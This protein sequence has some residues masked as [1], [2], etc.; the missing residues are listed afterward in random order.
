MQLLPLPELSKNS[1][2][3]ETGNPRKDSS[4]LHWPGVE[5]LQRCPDP[6]PA[7]QTDLLLLDYKNLKIGQ[8]LSPFRH[9]EMTGFEPATSGLQ[10]RRSPS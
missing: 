7:N 10:N 2:W 9:M 1:T 6:Q 3:L 4:S 8:C 5:A